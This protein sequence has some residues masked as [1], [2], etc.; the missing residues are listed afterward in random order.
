MPTELNIHNM[1]VSCPYV[2]TVLI[3]IFIFFKFCCFVMKIKSLRIIASQ[4]SLYV[5]RNESNPISEKEVSHVFK[6]EKHSQE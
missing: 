2:L 1:A 6:T 4:K 3:F 5:D